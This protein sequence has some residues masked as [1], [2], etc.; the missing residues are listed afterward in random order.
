MNQQNPLQ[1]QRDST[2]SNNSSFLYNKTCV[3]IGICAFNYFCV[4][5]FRYKRDFW[6]GLSCPT[7]IQFNSIL[8]LFILHCSAFFSFIMSA[9]EKEKKKKKK[10]KSSE[11]S[12]D[13]PDSPPL[14]AEDEEKPKKKKKKSKKT[15]EEEEEGPVEPINEDETVPEEPPAKAK[16]KKSKKKEPEEDSPPIVNDSDEENRAAKKKS[17]KKRPETVEEMFPDAEFKPISFHDENDNK[18]EETPPETIETDEEQEKPQKKKKKAKNR[19]E[20]GQGLEEEV[21]SPKKKKKAKK[22]PGEEEEEPE[23]IENP[24]K[25]KK[26][27]LRE[28]EDNEE[29]AAMKE[30]KAEKAP[31]KQKLPKPSELQQL[32]AKF[33]TKLAT[34]ALFKP[35]NSER[36][37]EEHDSDVEKGPKTAKAAAKAALSKAITMGKAAAATVVEKA[38]KSIDKAKKNKKNPEENSAENS[39]EKEEA[40]Q[41]G[42]KKPNKID[43]E[44]EV[45]QITKKLQNTKISEQKSE[46]TEKIEKV[47]GSSAKTAISSDSAV[48]SKEKS[49]PPNAKADKLVQEADQTIKKF[50]FG[51][52]FGGSREKYEEGI[53]LL[54]RAASEY[55]L[56]RHY[57]SAAE[58]H[59]RVA[60]LYRDKFK[61]YEFETVNNYV[62][63][64]QA[65]KN[66]DKNA[67]VRYYKLAIDKN[68]EKNEFTSAAKL[69]KEI[70]EIEEKGGDTTMAVDAYTN[71]QKLYAAEDKNKAYVAQMKGKIANLQAGDSDYKS[72]AKQ[73]ENLVRT[74][75][76][77]GTNK[78]KIKEHLFKAILCWFITYA[79]SFDLED[80]EESLGEYKDLYPQLDGSAEGK[81]V[82]SLLDSFKEDDLDKFNAVVAKHDRLYKLDNWSHKVITEIGEIL[83]AGPQKRWNKVQGKGK[84]AEESEPEEEEEEEKPKSKKAAKKGKKTDDDDFT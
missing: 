53:E 79:P 5:I 57:Q 61:G 39:E 55:K 49:L 27:A 24:K 58:I 76:E 4:I 68:M 80:V 77:N 78:F 16:K 42:S 70:G 7:A 21:I 63:A 83:K 36:K 29:E 67:A 48:E 38:N 14:E 13:Y 65:A 6:F 62:D 1:Q 37:G 47:K 18:H 52:L 66:Y 3:E 75:L 54:L 44:E 33:P 46:K 51:A 11:L 50:K 45:E 34:T 23:V 20:N 43:Q 9:A 31:K 71:A 73:F 64:G 28:E 15:L 8:P 56:T 2:T 74:S 30:E 22:S 35:A 25:T 41:K 82:Q 12:T 59:V 60:E 19:E 69:W 72:A 26:K 81:L 40:P 32:A 10:S 84:A 17:K